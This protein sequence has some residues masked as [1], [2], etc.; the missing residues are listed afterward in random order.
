LL[1]SIPKRIHFIGIGGTGMSA[2]ADIL[3][4]LGYQV[5]GSDLVSTPVTQRLK[6]RGGKFYLGHDENNV[7]DAGLIVVSTAINCDNPELVLAREKGIPAI[8]RAELLAW[9]MNRQKGIAVAGAHGKTTTTSMLA[10]TLAKNGFDPTIIIGGELDDIG[11][12]AKLGYGEY[13]VAE[14]DESDGSFLKLGPFAAIV[15]NI[16]DDHLDH[17]GTI[18]NIKAAFKTFLT[19]IPAGGKA[20]VYYDDPN[21]RE[22]L[23]GL[24][25]PFVSYGLNSHSD[26][27]LKNILTDGQQISGDVY[28][29]GER[30]GPLEL[31]VPGRH[32]LLNAL[33]VVALARWLGLEFA[34]I[35][36]ALK[37]FRGVGR[38]FH[39]I[40][41]AGGIKI[42]DDYAHHP[43]EIK[44]TLQAARALQAQRII[45]VFQPHRY[46][47]TALLYK[48]FG[49]VF[50][51]ADQVVMTEIYS[52]GESPIEGVT[53]QLIIDAVQDYEGRQVSFM[54]TQ[55][56]VLAHL[57]DI[58]Q[59]G[60]LVLTLGAGNIWNVGKKLQQR[61]EDRSKTGHK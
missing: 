5:S 19:K 13:V 3:L 1:E 51:D 28:F 2:L 22:V 47:R 23:S 11:G 17:Y 57:L 31:F 44:A 6:A 48:R 26:Y 50:E 8:H 36:G 38:R 20:V 42:F 32:N 30:L 39:F 9:L 16:E 33:G 59:A 12:N 55:E 14:S 35:T 46:T 56:E 15:T 21:V 53:A 25:V 54:P 34:Q 37:E 52:A 10:L 60:D 58:V 27:A 40:G 7:Q 29:H 18:E 43:T 49:D 41:E 4:S 61:L 24:E 45:A